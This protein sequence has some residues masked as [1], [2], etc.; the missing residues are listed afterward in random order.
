MG[1]INDNYCHL[2][3]YYETLRKNPAYWRQRI[4][5][6][7]VARILFSAAAAAAK[8]TG[9]IFFFLFLLLNYFFVPPLFTLAMYDDRI[10]NPFSQTWKPTEQHTNRPN[11]QQWSIVPWLFRISILIFSGLFPPA[12]QP[13]I[14]VSIPTFWEGFEMWDGITVWAIWC[15]DSLIVNVN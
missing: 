7:M 4:S 10:I 5:Q 14:R 6:P 15:C 11:N 9:S 13:V 2:F 3:F 8:G 1:Q 12:V